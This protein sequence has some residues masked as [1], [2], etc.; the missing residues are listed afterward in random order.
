VPILR[1]ALLGAALVLAIVPAPGHAQVFLA[2]RPH[3][4]FAIGP[5]FVVASVRPDLGP[6]TVAISWSLTVP[7]GQRATDIE[8]DL[9]LLWPNELAEGTMPGAADPSLARELE[10]RGFAVSGGGRLALGSR[11]RMQMGTGTPA[12][13]LPEGASF[14]SFAR[15]AG[16]AAQ[17]GSSTYIKIPWTPKL[18]DP[19]AVAVLTLTTRGL[20]TPKPAT[21]FEEAFWGRRW[22]LAAGFG[23]LG[24]PALPLFPLYFEH[25]DRVVRLGREFAVVVANFSD[26]DHLRIEEVGPASATRRP[27]RLRAGAEIVTMP[28]APSEGVAAQHLKVQ[29]SYFT[30][31]IAWRPI[32]ISV[33]L[34][35][36]GNLAGFI[37]LSRDVSQFL[38][39]RLHVRSRTEP[40]FARAAGAPLPRALADRITPGSTSE[41]EV[42]GLCGRPDEEHHR[43]GPGVRR[44]LVYR[45]V[46]QLPSARLA[47]GRLATVHHWDEEHHELEVELEGDR[48]IAVQSR[49]RRLRVSG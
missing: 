10:A 14:V 20:V 4:Q 43:R 38:R 9:F 31:M 25:R 7:P 28:L 1:R 44:T 36:L 46:R 42:L 40:E 30:G 23:D 13:P 34:L 48:V 18:A 32:L 6:V 27:S 3:P 12:T 45:A 41:A 24:P 8:Q 17:L 2:S 35:A 47:L 37:L 11:D 29:F 26:S 15:R 33:V 21:W 49:V 16:P 5:L 39:N 22:V 19:M